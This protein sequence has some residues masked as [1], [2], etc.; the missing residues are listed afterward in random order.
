M[1]DE[2]RLPANGV[3]ENDSRLRVSSNAA[4]GAVIAQP[5]AVS[6]FAGMFKRA[7]RIAFSPGRGVSA[8]NLSFVPGQTL[9]ANTSIL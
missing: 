5:I 3:E 2:L 4:A 1:E 7:P 9:P 6:T 8:L